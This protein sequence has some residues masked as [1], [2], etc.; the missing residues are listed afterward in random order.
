MFEIRTS[1]DRDTARVMDIWRRAVDATHD[2]L[3]PHDRAAIEDELS[4]FLPQVRLSL[5]VDRTDNPLG[6][7]FLHEGHLE[8]LFID[9]DHH[10]RGMGA[11]LIRAAL[12]DHPDLTTDV[13]E[14]NPKAL[15][16]YERIGFERTGRS[17]CDG[18]GR[19]YPLIHLRYR[20]PAW[21]Q[22]IP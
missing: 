10:G 8:A 5:A 22:I 16:F 17:S 21:R 6:F 9:P 15:G 19:P 4:I 14:Q 7:M 11:A 1:T 3:A 18:Q 13:N 2:F 12:A 20:L